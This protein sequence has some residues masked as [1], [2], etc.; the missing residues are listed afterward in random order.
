MFA[1]KRDNL[2]NHLLMFFFLDNPLKA[3]RYEVIRSEA[4]YNVVSIIHSKMY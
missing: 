2:V 4:R 3:C 1:S